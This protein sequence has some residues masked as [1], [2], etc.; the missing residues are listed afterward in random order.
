MTAN[1]QRITWINRRLLNVT[2]A[3]IW[4]DHIWSRTYSFN[5]YDYW[6]VQ[7]EGGGRGRATVFRWHITNAMLTMGCSSNG[8]TTY[9]NGMAGRRTKFRKYDNILPHVG[10]RN[11]RD[12]RF[13]PIKFMRPISVTHSHI[14]CCH[15]RK[16]LRRSKPMGPN[17]TAYSSIMT[18]H[19][20]PSVM[21]ERGNIVSEKS[22]TRWQSTG[23]VYGQQCT[24][25]NYRVY[26]DVENS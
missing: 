2:V 3:R 10:I 5:D 24:A 16:L 17:G 15:F 21:I 26:G 1:G 4:F 14:L 18:M 8:H 9:N 22:E 25:S 19:Q 6:V 12:F 20:T 7:R 23:C 13:H 11:R